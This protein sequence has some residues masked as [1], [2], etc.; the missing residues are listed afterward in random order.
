MARSTRRA[1]RSAVR[2]SHWRPLALLGATVLAPL[3]LVGCAS[4]ESVNPAFRLDPKEVETAKQR[5]LSLLN[6]GADPYSV[7]R[8]TTKSVN[9][10]VSPE[11]IL[12]DAAMS[13]PMD[14]VAFAVARSGGGDEQNA[15]RVARE[16]A[17][18]A[19]REV[20]FGVVLQI[21]KSRDPSTV[22]FELR[23]NAGQKYPPLAVE[24]PQFLREVTSALDPTTP[25]GALYGYDV[26]FPVEGSPGY[27]PIGADVSALTL[28][29]RDG[30]AEGSADFALA[31]PQAGRSY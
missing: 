18:R 28:V 27:P 9:E 12:Q 23:T 24:Q 5:G 20:K 1:G 30:E 11:V 19:S 8:W 14:E 7:Y 26:R 4:S 29:V 22:Q 16:A 15:D 31:S 6:A 2:A 3:L 25:P 13:S 21:S 17:R 10:R